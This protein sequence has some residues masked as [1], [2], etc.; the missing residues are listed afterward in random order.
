M[1]SRFPKLRHNRRALRDVYLSKHNSPKFQPYRGGPNVKSG[2]SL[3]YKHDPRTILQAIE[4]PHIAQLSLNDKLQ[5]I[6]QTKH[7]KTFSDSSE[8]A[9]GANRHIMIEFAPDHLLSKKGD[10]PSI[11]FTPFHN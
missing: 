1:K 5:G 4:D 7:M 10:R 3:S 8:L 9:G 6:R 2:L 11:L